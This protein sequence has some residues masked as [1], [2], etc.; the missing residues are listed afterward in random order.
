MADAKQGLERRSF[1]MLGVPAC[2]ALC[3]GLCGSARGGLLPQAAAQGA[4]PAAK[5]P[6]DEEVPR[7]FT[8]RQMQRIQLMSSIELSKYLTRTMGREK[9]LALL[10][11]FADENAA[12][13]APEAAKQVGGNDF[14]GVKKLFSPQMYQNRLIMEVVESTDRVHQLKVTECLWARTCLDASAGEEGYASICHGDY[15]F[16]TAFNP[17]IEMLR[18]K[19]LMQ[20]HGYCNHRYQLKA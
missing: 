18:D 3:A 11:A 7:K 4:A 8:F 9:A 2:A 5:H 13:Q 15:A 14:V 17:K 16:A 12:R 1:L 20:G 10:R 19:T 6:F